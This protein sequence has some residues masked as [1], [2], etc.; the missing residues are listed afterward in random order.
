[1]IRNILF[2]IGGVLLRIDYEPALALTDRFC[3]PA[4]RGALRRFFTFDD[5][6]P[7]IREYERGAITTEI[8][9]RHFATVTGFSGAVDQFIRT[10]QNMLSENKPML[11]FARE[12]SRKYHTYL[13]TNI[14]VLHTPMIYER[15]PSLLF[16]KDEASSCYLGE[17]KPDR[18]FYQKALAKFGVAPDTCLLIDDRA[19][20]IAGAEAFGIRAILYTQPDETIAAVRIFLQGLLF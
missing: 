16:S 12:M 9:F 2:D 14:G 5:R 10:Y 17:V 6:D 4:K 7:M 15:F 1:M 8:F 18:A 3:D 20:N 13:V 19:E 11:E